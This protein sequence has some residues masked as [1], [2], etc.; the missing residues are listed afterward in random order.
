MGP[1][2]GYTETQA[3]HILDTTLGRRTQLGRIELQRE[4]DRTAG[5]LRALD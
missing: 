4:R 1:G 3:N 5:E 2:F